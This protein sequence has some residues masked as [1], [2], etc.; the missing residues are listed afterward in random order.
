MD[1]IRAT[2]QQDGEEKGDQGIWLAGA[3]DVG[4]TA[5]QLPG[6]GFGIARVE[7]SWF[8]FPER[9]ADDPLVVDGDA[10]TFAEASTEGEENEPASRA[11]DRRI[12]GF[13]KQPP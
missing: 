2:R 12:T 9:L 7:R 5:K 11:T 13:R 6:P 1:K 3:G 4:Q 10:R 8:R